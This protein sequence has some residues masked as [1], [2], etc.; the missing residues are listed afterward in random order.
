MFPE[1][2][3]VFSTQ[4][5]TIRVIFFSL[6]AVIFYFFMIARLTMWQFN[7]VPRTTSVE[8]KSIFLLFFPRYFLKTLVEIYLSFFSLK[9]KEFL[10]I[11][12]LSC[13]ITIIRSL[14]V[15]QILV[16]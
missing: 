16:S 3:I 8:I 7:L 14:L 2:Y 6:G 1:T 15:L 11:T 9:E 4:N 5:M 12:R 10:K 13:F